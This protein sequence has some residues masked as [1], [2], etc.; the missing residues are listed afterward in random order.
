MNG[1]A[2]WF[3]RPVRWN[4]RLRRVI[5]RAA[6]RR[7]LHLTQRIGIIEQHMARPPIE[8]R[9]LACAIAVSLTL[10]AVAAAFG[11]VHYEKRDSTFLLGYAAYACP[12]LAAVVVGLGLF[13]GRDRVWFGISTGLVSLGFTAFILSNGRSPSIASLFFGLLS[14]ACAFSLLPI[15]I[16]RTTGK[17][18][19]VGYWVFMCIGYGLSVAAYLAGIYLLVMVNRPSPP[20]SKQ[21]ATFQLS[22]VETGKDNK[23][24]QLFECGSI[25]DE[26][27]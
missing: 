16:K 6:E 15:Y 14:I 3:R 19:T 13:M 9:Q 25:D 12:S 1:I 26:K 8:Q 22:C 5:V 21:Q 10:L 4:G 18:A 11:Y 27:R 7:A 20:P 24:R 23:G 2:R 17:K